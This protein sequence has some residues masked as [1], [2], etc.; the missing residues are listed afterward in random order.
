MTYLMGTGKSINFFY[1]EL[2]LTQS[3]DMMSTQRELILVYLA[4]DMSIVH[5]DILLTIFK[6]VEDYY[7][8]SV[9]GSCY[10]YSNKSFILCT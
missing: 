3:V 8:V 1:T 5:I 2:L 6:P 9:F 4:V 7:T 10:F